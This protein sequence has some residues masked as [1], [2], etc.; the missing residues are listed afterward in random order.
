[1]IFG[2]VTLFT[3]TALFTKPTRSY[4]DA[5]HTIAESCEHETCSWWALIFLC[6]ASNFAPHLLHATNLGWLI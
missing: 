3:K 1:M 6:V 4:K 2:A 5:I